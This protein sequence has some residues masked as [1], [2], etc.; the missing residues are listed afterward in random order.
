MR[1]LTWTLL[2]AF[3][4]VASLPGAAAAQDFKA[5]IEAFRNGDYAAAVRQWTPLAELGSVPAQFNLGLI[6][7]RGLGQPPDPVE[8]V[9]WY[10]RAAEN[11]APAAQINLGYAY[12]T[13][14]GVALDYV[15]AY[16]WYHVAAERLPDGDRRTKAVRNR[17]EV[18][19]KMT[20]AEMDEA[21]RRA[22]QWLNDWR[23]RR[24][25]RS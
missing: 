5:G 21:R 13:G 20:A 18:A 7:D 22:R 3:S 11:G 16:K 6:Y 12:E 14:R 4:F 25:R 10:R 24:G 23:A 1:C 17:A 9:R 8:A 15:E 2:L 19:R